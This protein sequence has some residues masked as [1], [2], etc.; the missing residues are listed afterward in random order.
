M[1]EIKKNP[2]K[3]RKSVLMLAWVFLRLKL[4]K[5][6]F[7]QIWKPG[8]HFIADYPG[9]FSKELCSPLNPFPLRHCITH[10]LNCKVYFVNYFIYD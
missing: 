4:F 8:G 3:P 2:H 7:G 9:G 1:S 5:T 6:K 10:F